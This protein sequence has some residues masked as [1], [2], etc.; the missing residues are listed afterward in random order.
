[1]LHHSMSDPMMSLQRSGSSMNCPTNDSMYCSKNGSSM[2]KNYFSMYLTMSSMTTNFGSCCCLLFFSL[3]C[4]VPMS[5]CSVCCHQT[6]L[7]QRDYGSYPK[8]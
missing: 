4:F 5:S 1:M 3:W 7:H 8:M 6:S 2:M